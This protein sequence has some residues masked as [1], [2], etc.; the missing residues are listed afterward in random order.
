MGING[1]KE[2]KIVEENIGEA[3]TC[4]RQDSYPHRP[5]SLTNGE[6]KK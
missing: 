3:K 2:A 4:M 1:R 6:P 5:H